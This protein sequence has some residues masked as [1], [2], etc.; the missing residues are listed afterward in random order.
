M[1][2]MTAVAVF[3]L[4]T[5]AAVA[6]APVYTAPTVISVGQSADSIWI[7]GRSSS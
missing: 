5:M 3:D 6:G 4:M 2:T 7:S 1:M